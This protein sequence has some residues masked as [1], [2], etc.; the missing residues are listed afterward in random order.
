MPSNGDYS[1][2]QGLLAKETKLSA[3]GLTA[4]IT[5]QDGVKFT[6]GDVLDANAIAAAFEIAQKGIAGMYF[7]NV[8]SFKAIDAKTLEMVFKGPY[9]NFQIDFAQSFTSIFDA[10]VVAKLGDT[11]VNAAVG[12]GPYIVESYTPGDTMVLKAN[13]DYWNKD[14]MAHIETVNVKMIPDENTA[15][16]ALQSGSIQQMATTS[17]PIYTTIKDDKTINTVKTVADSFIMWY[18]ESNPVLANAKVREALAYLTDVDSLN[19]AAFDGTGTPIYGGPWTNEGPLAAPSDKY[20]YNKEKGLALLAEAGVKPEDIKLKTL[21]W[22]GTTTLNTAVQAQLKAVGITLDFTTMEIGA[23]MPM[24]M[25]GQWDILINSGAFSAANPM[26]AFS[27][28]VGDK[29]FI[30]CTFFE[31]A[32]PAAAAALSTNMTAALTAK[33]FTAQLAALKAVDQTLTDNSAYMFSIIKPQW[34]MYTNASIKNY[35]VDGSVPFW[36]IYYAYI[37]E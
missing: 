29:P 8:A 23:I 12:S 16:M 31:T 19:K 3:D 37:A 32:A 14:K 15:L 7:A 20:K 22:A 5:I 24:E 17:V 2:V 36:L 13:A 4:T 6:N 26:S 30:K 25:Q 10:A 35:V 33:D 18:N 21:D 1:N 11:D 34:N 28:L 9:A 27:N